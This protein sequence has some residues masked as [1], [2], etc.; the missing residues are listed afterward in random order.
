MHSRV[1]T[2]LQLKRLILLDRASIKYVQ[3]CH[4]YIKKCDVT[5]WSDNMVC[6]QVRSK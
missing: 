2:S 3:I 1:K 6:A 5:Q 4:T